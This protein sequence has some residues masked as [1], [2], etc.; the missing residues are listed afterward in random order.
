[1]KPYDERFYNKLREG[2]RRSAKA[3]AAVVNDLVEPRSVV[4]VGC[5]S[6]SFAAAFR[7]LGA[8][9]KGCDGAYALESGLDIPWRTSR[10]STSL[11]LKTAG[12]ASPGRSI[13]RYVWKSQNTSPRRLQMD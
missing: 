5:G 7:Q 10:R 4:D 13:W 12:A 8:R 6:A 11:M 9:V 2:A 3:V 1:M